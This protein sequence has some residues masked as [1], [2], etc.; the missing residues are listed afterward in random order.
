MCSVYPYILADIV[1]ARGRCFKLKKGRFRLDAR[2]KFFAQRVERHWQRLPRESALEMLRAR[3]AGAMSSL[4]WWGA[5][6]SMAVVGAWWTLRCLPTQ[7]I[8]C[9]NSSALVRRGFE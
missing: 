7:A 2:R 4:N 5:A 1:R 6:L 8:L 3:L 9:S